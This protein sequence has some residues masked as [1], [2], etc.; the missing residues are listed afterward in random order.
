MKEYEKPVFQR[1][2]GFDFTPK[3]VD[4]EGTEIACRFDW[5]G[6][7]DSYKNKLTTLITAHP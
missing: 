3:T 6:K 4:A 1:V 7:S 5:L 2:K